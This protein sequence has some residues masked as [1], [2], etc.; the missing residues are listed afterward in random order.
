MESTKQTPKEDL[1]REALNHYD[2]A[3]SSIHEYRSDIPTAIK[4]YYKENQPIS[5]NGS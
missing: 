1:I 3:S 5:Q 4:E 2:R